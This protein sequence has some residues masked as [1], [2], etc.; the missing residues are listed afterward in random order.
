MIISHYHINISGDETSN[1]TSCSRSPN[2]FFVR[3][4]LTFFAARDVYFFVD[5]SL[6]NF[7]SGDETQIIMI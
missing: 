2:H 4:T 1:E 5:H 3:P 6:C 7:A